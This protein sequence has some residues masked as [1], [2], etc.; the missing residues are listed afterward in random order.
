MKAWVT[1]NGRKEVNLPTARELKG[2][3]IQLSH[4]PV[5]VQQ[6]QQQLHYSMRSLTD[7]AFMYGSWYEGIP[8]AEEWCHWK[9][10]FPLLFIPSML[11]CRELPG[12]EEG[13]NISHRRRKEMEQR[14]W[15]LIDAVV[16]LKFS[17]CFLSFQKWVMFWLKTKD[18]K[19]ISRRVYKDGSQRLR[20][21]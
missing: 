19:S 12:G 21:L 10:D 7:R 18:I 2:A 8:L 13:W 11:R 3:L 5:Q 16:S 14:D 6:Q 4:K 15:M 17:A 1:R 20:F 9:G